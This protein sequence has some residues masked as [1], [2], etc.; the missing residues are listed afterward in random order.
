M[1]QDNHVLFFCFILFQNCLQ[2]SKGRGVGLKN[3]CQFI[4]LPAEKVTLRQHKNDLYK[5]KQNLVFKQ[6]N[7]DFINV[8]ELLLFSIFDICDV[9]FASWL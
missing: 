5:S 6:T 1:Q 7:S 9:D 8:R 4:C 2:A 3:G